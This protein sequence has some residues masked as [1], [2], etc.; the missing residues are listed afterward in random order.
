MCVNLPTA[1]DWSVV[2]PLAQSLL[3]SLVECSI[4]SCLPTGTP[5]GRPAGR[6]GRRGR[7][8]G[9]R[10]GH[11]RTVDGARGIRITTPCTPTP[12]VPCLGPSRSKRVRALKGGARRNHTRRHQSSPFQAD[13]V[14]EGEEIVSVPI[15]SIR[16]PS[17]A[18]HPTTAPSRPRSPSTSGRHP[19]HP[20]AFLG[21]GP[22]CTARQSEEGVG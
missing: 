14:D 19:P 5:E 7:R 9:G 12:R 6:G 10:E 20:S 17:P 13:E 3:R 15:Q 11:R 4:V 22:G 8:G 18:P 21:P 2:Y 16:P 1:V